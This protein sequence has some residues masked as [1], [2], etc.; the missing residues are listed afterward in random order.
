MLGRINLEQAEAAISQKDAEGL[1]QILSQAHLHL[2]EIGVSNPEGRLLVE[3]RL[4]AM[5]LWVPR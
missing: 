2:K 1:G 3:E 5:V 4:L